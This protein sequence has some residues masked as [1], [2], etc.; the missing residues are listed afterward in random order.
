MC[1]EGGRDK[2]DI[3]RPNGISKG[4]DLKLLKFKNSFIFCF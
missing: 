1:E 4:F 3:F 2:V